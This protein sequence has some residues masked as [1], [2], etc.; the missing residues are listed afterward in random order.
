MAQEKSAES[1]LK[2]ARE[3]DEPVFVLRAK[4]ELSKETLLEYLALCMENS[5]S[6]EH[7]LGIVKIIKQFE[8]WQADYFIQVKLPD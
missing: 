2:S 7:C 1:V 5:C 4:D 6:E 8:T 3:N